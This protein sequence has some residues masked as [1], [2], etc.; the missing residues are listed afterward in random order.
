MVK[1]TLSAGET[2]IMK[3]IWDH[4]EDITITDLV[5]LV[6]TRYDKEYKR[7]TVATFLIRLS[8]KRF[9]STYRVGRLSYVHVEKTL[10]EYSEMVAKRDTE[11]WFQGRA[12]AYFAALC[13]GRKLDE[14]D[15]K[16]MRELLDKL[17]E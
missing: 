9:I 1:D 3:A 2:L 12:S 17:D 7:T 11:F 14:D 8:D 15:I 6:S 16:R 13:K 5:D 4:G 10:E